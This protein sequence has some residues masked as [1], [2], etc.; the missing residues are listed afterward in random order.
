MHIIK[1][2]KDE[3]SQIL[4]ILFNRYLQDGIFP[5]VLKMSKIITIK[6]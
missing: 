1:L 6:K 2:I 4:A 5:D 3:I